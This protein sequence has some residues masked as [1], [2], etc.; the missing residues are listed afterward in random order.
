MTQQAPGKS[1][2]KGIDIFEAARKFSDEEAVEKMFAES[3]W[4]NGVACPKCGSLSVS[5]RNRKNQPYRC[6]DCRSDFSVQTGTVMHGSNIPLT[7]W[8]MAL[9]LMTTGLKGVSSMKIHRDLGITQKSA[10]YMTHRIREAWDKNGGL[11][12]GPVEVDETYIGGKRKNMHGWKRAQL[13]GRGAAGKFPIAGIKDRETNQ[14]RT[15]AVKNTTKRTLQKFVE[16]NTQPDAQV[17]SDE[18]RA[19]QGLDRPHEAVSHSAGEYVRE[20]VHTNGIESHWATLKRGITGVYHHVSQKHVDRY[21]SEF[22]GRHNDRPL[23]T[24]EQIQGII[25]GMEGKHLSYEDLIGP[26]DTR[27]GR[28]L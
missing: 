1:Y 14:I 4:P 18:A 21:A 17:Y 25:A 26:E 16:E 10:W 2:R 20:M 11:L 24:I 22:E 28:G 6:R 19:Y 27:L 9:Y 13:E 8:A 5:R 15:K 12:S 23:D 7:H 3:R